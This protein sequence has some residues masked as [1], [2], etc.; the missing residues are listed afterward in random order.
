MKATIEIVKNR[1]WSLQFKIVE[2]RQWS[3]EVLE[4]RKS[5]NKKSFK[6]VNNLDVF[7]SAC[8][9]VPSIE[10]SI[11]ARAVDSIS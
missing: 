4:S 7:C 5:S 8:V 3:L 6:T 2:N 9:F 10:R 1:E 11:E